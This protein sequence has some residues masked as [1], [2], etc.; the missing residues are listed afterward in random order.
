MAYFDIGLEERGVEVCTPYEVVVRRDGITVHRRRKL[1]QG[2]IRI[3]GPIRVTNPV[4]TLVD[5]AARHD[6]D[7]VE[8]AVSRAE[9][10][11]VISAR[12]LRSALEHYGGW[13][14]VRLLRSILDRRTFRL[15]QSRLE[16]LFIPIARRAGLAS[17]LTQQWVNGYR[18]DF[19]WPDLG[20]VVETD[21]G[22]WHAGAAQQT[23]DRRRD[24]AHAAVGLT[25]LRFTHAQIRYEPAHVEAILRRVVAQLCSATA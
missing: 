17:P 8:D 9:L 12:A 1:E 3:E 16:R 10:K 19:Y 24:Q 2:H 21:G 5:F 11:K 25:T 15:T 23:I 13:P 22:E 14:G 4:L 20:L 7:D 6:R 18:V